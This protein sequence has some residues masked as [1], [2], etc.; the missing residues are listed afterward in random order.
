METHILSMVN[1]S[2]LTM[3]SLASFFFYL[4]LTI[5]TESLSSPLWPNTNPLYVVWTMIPI[6][7]ILD[8]QSRTLGILN[9]TGRCR[10]VTWIIGKCALSIKLMRIRGRTGKCPKKYTIISC[11]PKGRCMRTSGTN[12]CCT[13]CT[14]TSDDELTSRNRAIAD[15]RREGMYKKPTYRKRITDNL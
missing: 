14:R 12:T 2:H 1:E 13:A 11:I 7:V 8:H 15:P 10:V 4:S 5:L 6:I 9:G 3:E